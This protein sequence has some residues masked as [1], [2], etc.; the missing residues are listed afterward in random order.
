ME[1]TRNIQEQVEAMMTRLRL[2]CEEK[3]AEHAHISDAAASSAAQAREVSPAR[4][5][6][7]SERTSPRAKSNL[8]L[9]AGEEG[10]RK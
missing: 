6:V 2:L 10:R 1:G 8:A 9:W 4:A 5:A 7:W 3:Q